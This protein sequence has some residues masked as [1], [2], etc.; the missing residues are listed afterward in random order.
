M[1]HL[2]LIL[3]VAGGISAVIGTLLWNLSLRKSNIER[4][5][6]VLK[7][8][9][10]N[11]NIFVTP[12]EIIVPAKASRDVP[13]VITNNYPY[14]VFMVVLEIKVIE[15][16]LDLTT[17]FLLEPM[18]SG[19]QQPK[20]FTI[21]IPQM[22]GNTSDNLLVKINGSRYDKPSTIKLSIQV[23]MKEPTPNFSMDSMRELPKT[24]KLPDGFV[25]PVYKPDTNK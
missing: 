8:F 23:Y 7:Q 17:N 16:D 6:E 12:P 14:P 22:N 3:I 9:S 15:G 11:E 18:F 25:P 19:I 24:I 2:A 13:I 5:Q 20:Y 4:H 10:K 21:Q 1:A